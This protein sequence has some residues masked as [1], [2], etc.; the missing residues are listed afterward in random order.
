MK[1]KIVESFPNEFFYNKK[2]PFIS[3]YQKTSRY[4]EDNKHDAL[5]FKNLIRDIRSS[6]EEKYSKTEIKKLLDMLL[7]I[8]KDSLFWRDTLDGIALF[9]TLDECI[10]Y[11]L[12]KPVSTYAIVADSF[13]IK[14]L[15]KYFQFAQTYQILDIDGKS[16]QV[17]ESDGYNLEK[18]ELDDDISTTMEEILGKDYSDSYLTRGSYGGATKSVFHGHGG[19]K[20]EAEIDLEKFFRQADTIIYDNVSKAS[21][22]PLILLSPSRHHSLFREISNNIYLTNKSI[23]GT[24]ELLGTTQVKKHIESSIRELFTEKTKNLIEQYNQLRTV[25]KSSDQL[26]EIVSASVDGRI[27]IIFIQE[28]KMIPGKIDLITKKIKAK[29]LTHPEVDDI[30]DDL[31]QITLEKGGKVFILREEEM[32]TD[33]GVAAIYRY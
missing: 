5:V 25:E 22:L 30:L 27:E 14:P 15:I 1:Y 3:I 18:I 33:S 21:K 24:Y 10:I 17:F 26:I 19:R 23:V 4:A 31:A 6:L 9:A 12:K 28:N 8:E 20:E 2:A 29:E 13:H 16:F 32:P 11:R 7:K